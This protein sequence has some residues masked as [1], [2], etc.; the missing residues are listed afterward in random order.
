MHGQ[1][2]C[3]LSL[4]GSGEHL[5]GKGAEQDL[6]QASPSVPTPAARAGHAFL[7]IEWVSTE[8]PF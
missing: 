4:P 6:S 5:T 3:R 8:S 7:F 1:G 2:P